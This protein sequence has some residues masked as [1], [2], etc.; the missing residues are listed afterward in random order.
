VAGLTS[1]EKAGLRLVQDVAS[2][3]RQPMTRGLSKSHVEEKT[4]SKAKGFEFDFGSR[5]SRTLNL[6]EATPAV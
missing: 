4:I 1:C 5:R 2:P 3:F 6:L